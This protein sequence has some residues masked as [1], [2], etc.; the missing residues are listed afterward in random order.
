MRADGAIAARLITETGVAPSLEDAMQYAVSAGGKRMRPAL[1]YATGDA[2]GAPAPALDAPAAAIEMVHAYSLVHDDLPAMDDD[3]LRRGQPTVHIRFDE[4]T[5][6]LAG[7]ALQTQAFDALASDPHNPPEARIALV[8][9]LARAAGGAGMAGG[10]AIDL[11]AVSHRLNLAQLQDMHRRKTGALI[12]AAVDM[13][14]IAAGADD[15][16]TAALRRYS[17]ALGLAF[18]IA[19]DILDVT[20]DTLT[21]GKRQGADAAHGKPT[22]CSELGLDGARAEAARARDAAH[23]AL[24]PLPTPIPALGALV[25]FA[26][27]RT[28]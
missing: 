6:L 4:A 10:Q 19:D 22:Y 2:L 3:D 17:A 1:V 12:Q 16:T 26:V 18:Q 24:D 9:C 21:L 20:A 13:G 7:D 25:D 23:A 28:H 8:A 5:A 15:D 11:A 14:A 27:S